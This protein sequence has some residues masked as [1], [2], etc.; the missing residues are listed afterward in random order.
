MPRIA[1][2]LNMTLLF[3][4]IYTA[5][6]FNPIAKFFKEGTNFSHVNDLPFHAAA[7]QGIYEQHQALQFPEE[8]SDSFTVTCA[9]PLGLPEDFRRGYIMMFRR[10]LPGMLYLFDFRGNTVWSHQLK[11][12]G[13]KAVQFT[14]NRTFLCLLGTKEYETGYGNAILELSLQGD[15]LLYLEKG[16]NDF[17]QTL[18]HEIFLNPKNEIVTLCREQRSTTFGPWVVQQLIQ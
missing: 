9:Q 15:T 2:I 1:T 6:T 7:N 14:Q 3:L 10:E 5:L 18:H 8:P 17:V 13:F 11:D 16:Q 12:A 4:G